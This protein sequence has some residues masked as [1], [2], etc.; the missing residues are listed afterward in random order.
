MAEIVQKITTLLNE[1]EEKALMINQLQ[2][3][4][5]EMLEAIIKLN[6]EI[7]QEATR[8]RRNR[9]MMGTEDDPIYISDEEEMVI[10]TDGDDW[11]NSDEPPF[12]LFPITDKCK[13]ERCPF[14]NKQ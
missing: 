14:C 1:A 13:M 11:E 5:A 9:V 8:I 6:D 12:Y 2:L 3:E 4:V 10:T 7:I